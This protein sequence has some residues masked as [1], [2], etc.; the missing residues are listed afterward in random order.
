MRLKQAAA[1]LAFMAAIGLGGIAYAAAGTNAECGTEERAAHSIQGPDGATYLTWAPQRDDLRPDG[2]NGTGCFFGVDHGADP[3]AIG[4]PPAAWPAYNYAVGKA[5]APVE[6][7]EGFKSVGFLLD[8]Y[9][10]LYTLHRESGTGK[11]HTCLFDHEIHVAIVKDD[12][13]ELVY[14]RSQLADFGDAR[15]NRDETTPFRPAD[16]PNQHDDYLARVSAGTSHT[17]A[18]RLE[19]VKNAP[20]GQNLQIYN[21]WQFAPI[22]GATGMGGFAHHNRFDVSYTCQYA[23]PNDWCATMAATGSKGLRG[24]QTKWHVRAYATGQASGDFCTDP[25]GRTVQDCGL[26]NSVRQFIKPGLNL[27]HWA[28]PRECMEVYS[29]RGRRAVCDPNARNQIGD[30]QDVSSKVRADRN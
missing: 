21:P 24:T 9:R 20:D 29:A 11:G 23:G 6:N 15:Y 13:G 5:G 22:Y 12:T 10:Y 25:R 19:S 28:D 16:C 7:Q 17:V 18:R 4:I 1:T 8:G 27:D 30:M 26:T 2:S 14:R 3:M